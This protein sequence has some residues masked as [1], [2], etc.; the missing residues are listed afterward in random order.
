MMAWVIF[1]VV[2][3]V[4]LVFIKYYGKKLIEKPLERNLQ[5]VKRSEN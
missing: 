3:Y 2:S 5:D 1:L 4:A